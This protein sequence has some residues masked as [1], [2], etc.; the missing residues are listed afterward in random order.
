MLGAQKIK[1]Q[2]VYRFKSGRLKV[3]VFFMILTR[4]SLK[5]QVIYENNS[6]QLGE[7]L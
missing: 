2:L 5:C 1:I 4:G 6:V 3:V 7:N